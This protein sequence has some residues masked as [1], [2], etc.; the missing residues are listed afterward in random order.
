MRARHGVGVELRRTAVARRRARAGGRP[1]HPA[2]HRQPPSG[3]RC[4][5]LR[6][7]S[8]DPARP[9]GPGGATST[10]RRHRLPPGGPRR[11]HARTSPKGAGRPSARRDLA[12]TPWQQRARRS[13]SPAASRMSTAAARILARAACARVSSEN[14]PDRC[15]GGVDLPLRKAKQRQAGLRFSSA[16]VR[17]RVSRFGLRELTTKSMDFAETV[18][19]RTRRR[20]GCQQLA[21]VLRILCGL[22]PAATQLHDFGAIEQALAAIAHEIRLRGTPSCER[23]RPLV[24]TT[25]IEDLLTRLPARC[26]RYRPPASATRRL[27]SPRPSPR[28]AGPHPRGCLRGG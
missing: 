25:Q 13:R 2:V 26:S 6:T 24:R 16:L 18:E 8:R 12:T 28:R 7:A 19:R 21:G 4:S 14:T 22:I 20:P 23:R 27:R 3:R 9:P 17:A 1:D 11:R 10:R 5:P 15:G